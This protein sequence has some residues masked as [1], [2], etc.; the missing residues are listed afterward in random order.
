VPAALGNVSP[1]AFILG[2]AIAA[3]LAMAVFAHANKRG[4]RHATAW[5][6]AT[7]L[8]AAIAVPVYVIRYWLRS[9]SGGGSGGRRY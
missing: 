6:I 8:F 4:N 5:G 1:G 2:V 9:R 7:F 3:G